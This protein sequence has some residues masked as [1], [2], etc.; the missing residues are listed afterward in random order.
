MINTFNQIHEKILES[1]SIAL[2]SHKFPDG[3]TLWSATAMYEVIKTNFINKHVDIVNYDWVAEKLS[4]LHNSD[5]VI[6]RFDYEKYDLCI[7]LDIW[8]IILAWY[9]VKKDF[10]IKCLINIDH[11]ATNVSYGDINL[12]AT[13]KPSTTTVLYDFFV[14][15]NYKINKNAATSLL[16]WIYTDTGAFIYSNVKPETFKISA[17]LVELGWNINIIASNFFLNNTFA[18]IKLYNIVVKRLKISWDWVGFSYLL[19][20]DILESGCKY[21]EMD[22]VVWRLNMLDNVKYVCFLYE[23]WGLVKGSLRTTR[24]DVDL[25]QY[26]KLYNWWWHKKACW[27]TL[28]WHISMSESKKIFVKCIDNSII[29]FY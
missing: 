2:V 1:K 14:A 18:F 23:K 9:W 10:P 26:A 12:I 17:E 20:E 27:F 22:W 8:S 7:F 21:E 6:S 13:N 11:H 28:E 29:N 19:K 4:F 15:M 16:T 25:T 24:D 3:D 5:K